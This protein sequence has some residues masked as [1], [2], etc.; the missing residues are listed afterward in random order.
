MLLSKKPIYFSIQC[1]T[2][3]GAPP[4]DANQENV[5]IGKSETATFY[6]HPMSWQLYGF[7]CFLKQKETSGANFLSNLVNSRMTEGPILER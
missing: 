2:F 6:W 3:M 7:G 1:D 4:G 5:E